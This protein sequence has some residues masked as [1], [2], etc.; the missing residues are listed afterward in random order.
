MKILFMGTPD[1]AVE[2]LEKII[3]AGHDVCTVITQPDRV[4]GRGFKLSYPAVKTCAIKYN[5]P[6]VQPESI[7]KDPDLILRLL[8]MKPDLFVIVAFGQI[9]PEAVLSIPKFGCI[10]VHA[11]LLPKY[12]GAAPINWA[13]INGEKETGVTTMLMDEGLDTG[14]ILLKQ[15]ILISSDET[16]GELHDRL[17]VIGADLLINTIDKLASGKIQREKQDN[18]KFTYAPRINKET[19]KIDWNKTALNIKNLVRGL[20]PYPGAYSKIGR[21]KLKIWKAD[22]ENCNAKTPGMIWS[23]DKSGIHVY[24]TDGGII[25]K[26]VQAENGKK[27]D[28]YAYTLGH[29]IEPGLRFE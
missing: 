3:G 23:I 5:I 6:V 12:R 19:G 26:E 18:E 9:L 29:H 16:A 20:N 15:S 10:N 27:V 24:S 22:I 17:K 7:K 25:I 14:D 4:K 11:S 8:Q 1:F 21:V 2:A 13:I 28:A